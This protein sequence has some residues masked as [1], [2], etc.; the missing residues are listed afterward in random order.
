M[1]V[2]LQ[3]LVNDA[4]VG[5]LHMTGATATYNAIVWGSPRGPGAGPQ[6]CTKSF[7]AELGCALRKNRLCQCKTLL[8]ATKRFIGYYL[9]HWRSPSASQCMAL[10]MP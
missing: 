9:N 2:V 1:P 5:A 8:S 10:C 7:E 6:L 4:R 3:A